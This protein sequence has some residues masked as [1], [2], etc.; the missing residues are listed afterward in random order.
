M[1]EHEDAR[2]AAR[3]SELRE[4]GWYLRY[5]EWPSGHRVLLHRRSDPA[6]HLVTE[7]R[8]TEVAAWDDAIELAE[9]R[10]GRPSDDYAEPGSPAPYTGA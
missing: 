6:E 7:W 10:G 3:K 5:Q 4:M 9:R 8:P 2:I 1:N